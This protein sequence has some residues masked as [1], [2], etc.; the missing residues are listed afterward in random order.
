MKLKKIVQGF[1][2]KRGE[3]FRSRHVMA[4]GAGFLSF[5]ISCGLSRGESLKIGYGA[6]SLG[7]ALIWITHEGRLFQKN[8][9]EV[10]VLYLESNLVRTALIA[11]DV[12]IGAMSGAAM[13]APRLQGADLVVILGFQTTCLFALLS[14]RRSNRHR[15][16]GESAWVL[17]AWACWPTGQLGWL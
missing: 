5:G 2:G 10:D 9:L 16:S 12:A 17:L 6:F 14:V 13:A 11:G 7:Y 8:G 4:L 3:L 15:I 1:A